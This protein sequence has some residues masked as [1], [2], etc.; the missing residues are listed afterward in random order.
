MLCK[1][2]NQALVD[3]AS[4]EKRENGSF[5]F[6]SKNGLPLKKSTFRYQMAGYVKDVAPNGCR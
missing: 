5:L 3:F 4:K 6:Q 1:P 2:L